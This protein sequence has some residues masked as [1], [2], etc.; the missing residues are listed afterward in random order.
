MPGFLLL[1]KGL[2]NMKK[3][4]ARINPVLL[5][6]NWRYQYALMVFNTCRWMDMEIHTGVLV[7]IHT[8]S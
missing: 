7:C 8:Y 4:E 3:E 2:T 1:E 5:D 6:W